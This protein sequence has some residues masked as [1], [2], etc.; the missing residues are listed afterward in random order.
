[1]KKEYSENTDRWGVFQ[2]GGLDPLQRNAPADLRVIV[3]KREGNLDERGNKAVALEHDLLGLDEIGDVAEHVHAARVV[4]T[5]VAVDAATRDEE[6]REGG[7]FDGNGGDHRY[8]PE[9]GHRN[10]VT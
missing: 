5:A 8:K 10:E 1:M 7:L 9:N 6:Q 4:A 2:C 3:R